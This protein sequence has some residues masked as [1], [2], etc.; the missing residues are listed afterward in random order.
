MTN[1]NN[2]TE[3]IIAV[4]T[5][6]NITPTVATPV[7]IP[8]DATGIVFT[9]SAVATFTIDGVT[10]PD[11]TVGLNARLQSGVIF[12]HLYPGAIIN[13]FSLTATINYQFFRTN[14]TYSLTS[15]R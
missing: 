1:V 4:G 13:F 2:N 10:T 3:S 14:D 9:S 5:H 15:R 6:Q 8:D 11:S 12:I 7:T